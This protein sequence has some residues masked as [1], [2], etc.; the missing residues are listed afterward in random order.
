MIQLEI[1]PATLRFVAHCLNQL[2]QRVPQYV[3]SIGAL[4]CGVRSSGGA[5]DVCLLWY[6]LTGSG[7]HTAFSSMGTGAL[8]RGKATGA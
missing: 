5:R 2:R 4:R 7:T 3:T 8:S 1:E 6:V